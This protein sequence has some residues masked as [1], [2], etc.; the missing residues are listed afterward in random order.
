MNIEKHSVDNLNATITINI[1]K[2]DYHDKFKAELKKVAGKATMKGFRKGKTPQSVIKKMYGKSVLAEVVNETLQKALSGYLE[3]EKLDILG[4]PIPSDDQDGDMNFDVNNL[5]D[6]SFKFD[7][8]LTP[9]IDIQGVSESD[10]Y[11]I[12]KIDV[13]DKVIDEELENAQKRLGNQEHPDGEIIPN[14]ILKIQAE[15]LDGDEPKKDG[16]ASEFSVLVDSLTEEYNAEVLK[17]SKGDTFT[18]DVF[19]LEKEKGDDY[20]KKYLLNVPK[21]EEGEEEPVIGNMF[22]GKIIDIARLKVAELDQEFYDKYFG[23]D[24][25]KS[26]EEARAK[27][28]EY[29]GNH[30][31][32]QALQVMYR[33]IMDKLVAETKVDLP[34]EFLKKWLKMTNEKLT[35]EEIE[36][37]FDG[38]LDNMKWTLI[39][40][41]LSKQ[42]EV[43]VSPEEIREAMANK[44]RSYFGQYGMDESY[45]NEILGK[46]LQNQEEVNKT[47]EELQ[48]GKL[49]TKIGETVSHIE[50]KISLEDFNEKVKVINEKQQP[51]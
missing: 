27:I 9:D 38:F 40:G 41:R 13:D 15:E 25:V 22:T 34:A 20:V 21:V 24:E 50:N 7:I 31:H 30:Y 8:G 39:K 37:D 4:Q 36:K 6:Y 26:E 12:Y 47:Y 44:V 35:D 29:I 10:T 14:D 45:V 16:W 18:F 1:S 17:L 19:K 28:Q 43:E 46:M 51:Q 32:N 11:D 23:K 5:E 2:E 49:F 33:N 42:F 3:E 48:A